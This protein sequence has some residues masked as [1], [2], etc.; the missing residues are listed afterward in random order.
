MPTSP[1][2]PGRYQPSILS[3]RELNYRVR[4]GN[5]WNLKAID[6]GKIY[7]KRSIWGGLPF[8]GTAFIV[9]FC[10]DCS[11]RWSLDTENLIDEKN[12]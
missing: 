8:C 11:G 4:N 2:F 12:R 6:T 1:I 3:D 7:G 5:G 9:L 10:P